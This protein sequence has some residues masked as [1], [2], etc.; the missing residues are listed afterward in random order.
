VRVPCPHI[1]ADVEY[2]LLQINAR[3]VRFDRQALGQSECARATP[4]SVR[5]WRVGPSG[6]HGISFHPQDSAIFPKL[7]AF[8]P[9]GERL[10]R[11]DLA[12]TPLTMS[13]GSI[14]VLPPAC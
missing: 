11:A 1:L 6:L 13:A 12:P 2:F 10:Q 14:I 5:P 3:A 9:L 7:N 8:K 4:F